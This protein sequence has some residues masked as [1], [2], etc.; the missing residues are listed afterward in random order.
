MYKK[1]TVVL[2]PFPFT[3]LSAIKVRPAVILSNNIDGDDV[4]VAFISAKKGK[5]FGKTDVSVKSSDK[6]F[7]KTGLKTDSVIK[8][9]K[10]ATLEK[11]T[12]LGE[13]GMV[14][15]D[16]ESKITRKLKLLFGL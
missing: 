1:N 14:S 13:L 11:K 7:L 16:I 10:I 8:V 3:D 9:G 12:I 4:L 6:D 5:K 15:K 2:L